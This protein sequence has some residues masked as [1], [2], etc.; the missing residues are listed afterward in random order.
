MHNLKAFDGI[1]IL[2]KEKAYGQFL[3]LGLWGV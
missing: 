3:P 1:N 2:M